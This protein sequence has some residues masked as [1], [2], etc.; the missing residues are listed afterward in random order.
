MPDNWR[1]KPFPGVRVRVI[2]DRP[3]HGQAGVLFYAPEGFPLVRF[4]SDGSEQWYHP[5]ELEQDLKFRVGDEVTVTVM[6]GTH[7]TPITR[8][9]KG[10]AGKVL[11]IHPEH[12]HPYRVQ[13]LSGEVFAFQ[14]GELAP[15]GDAKR[16]LAKV[17]QGP[18][19]A[20]VSDPVN[21]PS[22]YT[23][24]KGVEVIQ[25]TEQMNFNKGNAVKYV[26]RAGLK[27]AVTEIQDLE[28]ARWYINR[29][30]ER[31]KGNK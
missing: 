8:M 9:H 29:E 28:K 4:D 11:S 17:K 23:A 7:G 19:P 18:A 30:I 27:S 22:H 12:G 31:L 15:Y 24:Y 3:R 2:S 25:L 21:H 14:A 5:N 26:A 6:P 20:K 13:L 10:S 16:L 1:D